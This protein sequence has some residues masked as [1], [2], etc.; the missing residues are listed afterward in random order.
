MYELARTLGGP[1]EFVLSS[2]GHIQ[3]LLNP[4]GNPKARFFVSTAIPAAADEWLA[5]AQQRTGSWWE[6]WREWLAARSGP[7][8]PAPATLGSERHP[9]GIPAPGRYVAEA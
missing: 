6:H 9:A 2:S 5:G 3:S 1:G 7:R 4:P 8:G